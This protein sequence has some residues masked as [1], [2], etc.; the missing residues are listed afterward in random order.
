[1]S[2]T[3]EE[4]TRDETVRFLIEALQNSST[5]LEEE[6]IYFAD[7]NRMAFDHGSSRYV[8]IDHDNHFAIKIAINDFGIDQNKTEAKS[9]GKM[10]T[11]KVLKNYNNVIIITPEYEPL[12]TRIHKFLSDT[13][14][15]KPFLRGESQTNDLL[16]DIQ[17]DNFADRQDA[18]ENEDEF[19]KIAMESIGE[20]MDE[21]PQD[22]HAGNFG[23]DFQNKNDIPIMLDTGIDEEF[24]KTHRNCISKSRFDTYEIL[25]KLFESKSMINLLQ[26]V[27]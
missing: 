9:S 23:I 14:F 4:T 1:M 3:T 5:P 24:V 11:T 15:Q 7:E 12:E 22:V 21:Y 27:A 6:L 2:K 13:Y 10:Y 16:F 18:V 25:D 8:L 20:L 17:D 26:E 19:V